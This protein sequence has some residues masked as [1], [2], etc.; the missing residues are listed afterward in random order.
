MSK[1][2]PM[3]KWLSTATLFATVAICSL[4]TAHEGEDH[5]SD[6]AQP[7]LS[8]QGKR[9]VSTLEDYAAAVQSADIAEIEKYVITTDGFSSLEG[10]NHDAGWQSYRKHLADELPMFNE[11]SYSLSNI[12]PYVRGDMAFATMEYQMD[13]TIKSDRFDGGEHRVAMKGKATM[14]LS[15]SKNEWKIRHIHTSREQA[16]NSEAAGNAH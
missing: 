2:V 6:S 14:V 9:V 3:K 13:V 12:R 1:V 5:S 11:T 4:A 15:K 8:A 10:T 7:A 16:M